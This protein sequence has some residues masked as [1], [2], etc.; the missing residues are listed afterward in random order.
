MSVFE[1]IIN[2]ELPSI[3]IYEDDFTVAIHDK[4][5]QSPI[6]ILVLP[7]KKTKNIEELDDTTVAQLFDSVREVAKKMG[8]DK[9]GYRIIINNGEDAHQNIPYLHIHILG[10]TKLSKTIHHDYTRTAM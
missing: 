7:K 4:D 10:G 5:P 3:K 6:H 2:G 8:L 9:R 1:K